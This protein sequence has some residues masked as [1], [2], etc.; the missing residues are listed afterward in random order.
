M[1]RKGVGGGEP[2]IDWRK[3]I[4]F[5]RSFTEP[6]PVMKEES[7]AKSGIDAYHGHARFNGPRAVNVAG[8]VI[9]DR[10]VLIAADAVPMRVSVLAA[11]N[12]WR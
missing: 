5:K 2:L 4:A 6:V 11:T 12:T 3:L 8:E 1:R 9:E 7:F 10:F